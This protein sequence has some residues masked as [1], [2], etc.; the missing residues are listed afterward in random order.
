MEFN[1]FQIGEKW[2]IGSNNAST[3]RSGLKDWT[4]LEP[5]LIIPS[6]INGNKID[7]IGYSAFFG[8]SIIEEVYVENGIKQINKCCFMQCLNLKYFSIPQSV[9]L[10]GD[11][12][13]HAY[14]ISSQ[15]S[16]SGTLVVTI[17]P[18][19][20][21]YFVYNFGIARKERIIIHFYG[22][23][24][25]KYNGDP[26]GKRVLKEVKVYAPYVSNFLGEKTINIKI[27][28]CSKKRFN[29]HLIIISLVLGS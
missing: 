23:H 25:P 4:K 18:R 15:G 26:L 5:I 9:E 8:C 28:N 1:I 6:V 21:L 10:I 22:L 3:T 24:A 29:T 27:T 17:Q 12:A 14:N 11:G 20:K 7:E 2:I 13:I 16:S 19:S